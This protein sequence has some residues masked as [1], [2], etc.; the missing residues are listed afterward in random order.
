[1]QEINLI[2]KSVTSKYKGGTLF[3]EIAEKVLDTFH[4]EV[5]KQIL[6]GNVVMLPCRMSIEIIKT[7]SE[8]KTISK[9]R[10]VHKVKVARLGF[11]YQVRFNYHKLKRKKVRLEVEK[12]LIDKLNMVLLQTDF[13]YKLVSNG[14]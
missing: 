12:S 6:L 3:P 8:F 11:D 2:E 1:M 14:Y 9:S 5:V 7:V 4:E 10:H 13:D